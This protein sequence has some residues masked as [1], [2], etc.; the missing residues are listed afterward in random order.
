MNRPA[1]SLLGAQ[2][3]VEGARVRLALMLIAAV[4]SVLLAYPPLRSLM[5]AAGRSDPYSHILLIPFV[6]GYFLFDERKAIFSHT[7]YSWKIGTPIIAVGLLAYVLAVRYRLWLG[8]NDSAS[9]TTAAS[10]IVFWGGFILIYGPR[11]F[12]AGRFPL[13]FMLFAIPVPAF[14]LSRFI[15]LLQVGSTEVTQWLFDVTGT[16]YFRQGFMYQLA[17]INIEVA[18]EC[19]GIRSTLALII[20]CV[21]AGHLF[22]KSGWRQ[23]VLLIAILPVTILKNAIRIATLS[24]LAVYVDTRFITNSWLHHSGGFV[25]YIPALGL[26]GGM[27]CWLRKGEKESV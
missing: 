26:L 21:V 25:F 6:T 18:K 9:L 5:S 16:A 20:T 23:L 17:G 8:A 14:L 2:A 15:Y 24:F 1:E 27:L 22:L 4:V 12:A 10:I 11:S 13:L 3:E 19:S 7:W